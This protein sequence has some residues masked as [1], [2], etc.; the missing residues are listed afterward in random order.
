M[1]FSNLAPE[2][3]AL[4][5]EHIGGHELRSNVDYLLICK[6]WYQIALPIFLSGLDLT[7]V[8]LSYKDLRRLPHELAPFSNLL[9][10]Q[11]KRISIRLVGHPS[12]RRAFTPFLGDG[13]QEDDQREPDSQQI[14]S[15]RNREDV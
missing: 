6:N 13:K 4:I 3:L 5:A 8:Y 1:I 2:L 12:K 11:T 15:E 14:S 9:V 10:A 7:D